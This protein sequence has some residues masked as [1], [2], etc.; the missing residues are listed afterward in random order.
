MLEEGFFC[1]FKINI[2]YISADVNLSKVITL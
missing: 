2:K 1:A